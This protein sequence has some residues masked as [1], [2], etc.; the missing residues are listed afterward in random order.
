MKNS[1]KLESLLDELEIHIMDIGWYAELPEIRD[2]D[3]YMRIIILILERSEL[4]IIPTDKT[5][6][7]KI[8]VMKNE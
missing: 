6:S 1:Y 8:M 4:F 3:K 5:D 7:F 2:K